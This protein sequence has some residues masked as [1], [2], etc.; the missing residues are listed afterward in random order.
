MIL[1][2]TLF[3]FFLYT[4]PFHE[5]KSKKEKKKEV[6]H[7]SNSSSECLVCFLCPVLALVL[8][9]VSSHNLYVDSSNDIKNI[10][11]IMFSLLRSE[12]YL[13]LSS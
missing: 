4:D 6:S 1:I 13:L 9:S 12:D 5:V 11:A 10:V 7:C 3:F 2:D 8:S